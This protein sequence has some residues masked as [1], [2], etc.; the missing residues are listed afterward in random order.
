MKKLI[1]SMTAIAALFFASCEKDNEK[2]EVDSVVITE[3]KLDYTRGTKL[4]VSGWSWKDASLSAS[5]AD[6]TTTLAASYTSDATVSGVI[7]LNKTTTVESGATLT[8]SAGSEIIADADGTGNSAVDL[9]IVVKKGGK[10]IVD[11][12]ASNP[13]VMSSISGDP[14]TWGGLIICGQAVSTGGVD[15]PFEVASYPYGG[16]NS[17][18]SSGSLRYLVVRGSGAQIDSESQTNGISFCAVG[19]G[20]TVEFISV[21]DGG[22]DGVEFYGGSVAADNVHLEDNSDDSVDWTEGWD[23]SME[24]VNIVHN[25]NGFSTIF[26]GDKDN[27]N[28]MFT[29]VTAVTTVAAAEQGSGLQFKKASGATISNL[30]LEGYEVELDFPNEDLFVIENVII[31]GAIAKFIQ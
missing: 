19:S 7:L 27:G 23:G 29:N 8:I 22:D 13:V 1:L 24:N 31:N 30:Y 9:H 11:G 15:I 21:I 2:E 12:N 26:E 3:G 4:D 6:A 28:P 18:D 5:V 10:I 17:S 16:T 14:A 20:T 25:N